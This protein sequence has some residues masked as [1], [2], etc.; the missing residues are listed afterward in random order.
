MSHKPQSPAMHIARQHQSAPKAHP[1]EAEIRKAA[2]EIDEG[3]YVEDRRGAEE[4]AVDGLGLALGMGIEGVA[5]G[6]APSF[7]DWHREEKATRQMNELG[8]H[9]RVLEAMERMQHELEDAKTPD[10]EIEM[11]WRMHE[12]LA[13]DQERNKWA[14]QER[15][16]GRANEEMRRG[17]VLSPWQFHERLCKAIGRT[18]R[19]LLKDDRIIKVSANGKS[20]LLALVVRNPAWNGHTAIQHDYAQVKAREMR[21]AAEDELVKAQRLR[22]AHH[23]ADADKSFELAGDMI[24]TASEML[25]ERE[26]YETEIP[27]FLRVGTLQAPLGTEWMIMNF[28]EFGV[29]TSAK[30]TGWRTA[31]LTMVRANAITEEEAHRAFPV[32]SG[33]AAD[34]YLEQ[35]YM[36]RAGRLVVN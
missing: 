31:L 2:V 20:G 10:E 18:D 24:Q 17:E 6:N 35:L 26:A 11:R 8:R 33:P 21:E 14:G 13:A 9:P 28:D 1:A 3:R 7:E 29:P 25:L 4:R 23:N 5:V 19:V 27:E 12:L 32:G 16:E 36:R 22:K 30:Y 34:W 15:W